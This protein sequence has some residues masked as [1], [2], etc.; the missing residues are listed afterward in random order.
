[1]AKSTALS[2]SLL[3]YLL[4][5]AALPAEPASYW[6]ALFDAS[7][8]ELSGDGYARQELPRTTATFSAANA[9]SSSL[10]ITV[11]FPTATANWDA[12]ATA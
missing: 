8:V 2:N 6:L 12:I 9:K 11:T 7:D 10:A 5:G 3:N 1:M 4:R